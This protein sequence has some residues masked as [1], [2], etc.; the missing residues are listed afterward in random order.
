MSSCPC[1]GSMLQD[2][3]VEEGGWCDI[4]EEW[5]PPDRVKEGN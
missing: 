3:T 2:Y 1:C 5:I 4:D